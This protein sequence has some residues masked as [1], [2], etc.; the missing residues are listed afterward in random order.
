MGEP[1]NEDRPFPEPPEGLITAPEN[2]VVAHM[3]DPQMVAAAMDDLAAA[4]FDRDGIYVLCGAKG[5]ERLDVAGRDHGLKGRVYRLVE[6]IGDERVLL[7][8]LEEHL[9]AGGLAVSV[10]ADDEDKATAA[11]ILGEHGGHDM[12]HFG[13][14]HFEPVGP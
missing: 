12:A 8:R 3:D 9:V 6:R 7:L 1:G 2:R 5:A 11:H 14:G 13:K 10:P 4:G